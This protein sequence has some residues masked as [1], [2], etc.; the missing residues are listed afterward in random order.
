[1]SEKYV[2]TKGPQQHLDL[3]LSIPDILYKLAPSFQIRINCTGRS[4]LL[5][6][7]KAESEVIL[8]IVALFGN[9]VRIGWL[10]LLGKAVESITLLSTA[11]PEVLVWTFIVSNAEASEGA[12]WLLDPEPDIDGIG[13]EGERSWRYLFGCS[14]VGEEDRWRHHFLIGWH[15]ND[16]RNKNGEIQQIDDDVK[17]MKKSDGMAN[18]EDW[19]NLLVQLYMM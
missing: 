7:K 6:F 12:G 14:G 4:I 2:H 3:H 18:L 1:V 13:E 17:I 19:K 9:A 15:F 11:K 10:T 5:M 8:P 16:D